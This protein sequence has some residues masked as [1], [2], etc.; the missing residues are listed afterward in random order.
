LS[1]GDFEHKHH[2]GYLAFITLEETGK[3]RIKKCRIHFTDFYRIIPVSLVANLFPKRWE[4][5]LSFIF[6]ALFLEVW[7]EVVK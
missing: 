4:K 5:Y 6:P 2:I 7:L 3:Y 1:Y